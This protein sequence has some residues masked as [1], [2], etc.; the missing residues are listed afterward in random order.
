MGYKLNAKKKEKYDA[1]ETTL[2]EEHCFISNIFG[3][4]GSRLR[5]NKNAASKKKM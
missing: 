2:S 4:K 3:D 5:R 1:D